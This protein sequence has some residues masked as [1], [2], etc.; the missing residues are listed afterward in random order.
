[1]SLITTRER[2]HSKW[3]CAPSGCWIWIGGTVKN[4]YGRFRLTN[5][6]AGM[7]QAHRASWL[8]HK[9]PIPKG[10]MVCHRCD[11]RRCVNPDHL[12]LGTAKENSEDMV[13]KRRHHFG[14]SSHLSKLTQAQVDRIRTL[15]GSREIIA[16]QFGVSGSLI[17]YIRRGDVWKEGA[18][19]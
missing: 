6:K 1:M 16:R 7:T 3:E 17:G 18:N 5:D 14:E 8:L 11:N 19:V 12:F 4:G 13:S 2:F 10:M 15:A 9:G